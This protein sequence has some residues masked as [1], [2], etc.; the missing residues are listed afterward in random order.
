M[1]DLELKK[2]CRFSIYNDAMDHKVITQTSLCNIH[3]SPLEVEL[4][5][6][7]GSVEIKIS[8][9]LASVSRLNEV[10]VGDNSFV[11]KLLFHY[12]RRRLHILPL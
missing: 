7:S 1:E 3:T 5:Q 11:Q 6:G 9:Y 8:I 10:R 4:L 2:H 12:L